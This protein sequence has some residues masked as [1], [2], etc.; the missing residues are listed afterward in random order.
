MLLLWYLRK[1]CLTLGHK[2]ILLHF[3]LNIL[4]LSFTFISKIHFE[5]IF[6]VYGMRYS[7]M[8]TLLQMDIQLC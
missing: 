6:M 7:S 2:D 3:L 1:L 5:L 8:F 4:V